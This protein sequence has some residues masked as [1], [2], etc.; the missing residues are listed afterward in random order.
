MDGKKEHKSLK[1]PEVTLVKLSTGQ[2]AFIC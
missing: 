2:E 1:N